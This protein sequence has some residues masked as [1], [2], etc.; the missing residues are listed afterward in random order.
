VGEAA[1][2][3]QAWVAQLRC[4]RCTGR[5][6]DVPP[7]CTACGFA[8]PSYGGIPVVM[9]RPHD[10]VDQ[11]RFRLAEFETINESL[12]TRVIADAA[13]PALHPSTRARLERLAV[14]LATHRA[15]L[16]GLLADAGVT[17][18]KRAA[19]EPEGVPGEGS[20]TSYIHQIHR[21]WGWDA[22]GSTENHD[23]FAAVAAVL[24]PEPKLG[25]MLVLGA[26]AC[27]LA[28]DLH[29][30]GSAA[31][32]VAVDINPLPM[33]VSRRVL[34]GEQVRLLELPVAPP[35][36][37]HVAVDRRLGSADGP[38]TG[39]VHLFADA[40]ALPFADASFD[41][42]LTPWFI[43]Q[44]PRDIATLL[45]M[46][47]R[48]LRD[49]GRWINHGPLIY[50]PAHTPVA[51]R[52]AADELFAI[53]PTAGLHVEQQRVDRLTYLQSPACTRG[54]RESVISFVARAGELELCAA[55]EDPAWL[56]QVGLAVPRFAG[57][58]DYEAPHALFATV[59]RLLDG[60]RS[61]EEIAAI[62]V[63]DYSLPPTAAT[64]GV[65]ACLREIWRATRR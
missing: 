39:F 58:D 55:V 4:P 13:T 29:R 38:A 49:G 5:C 28:A 43:D 51:A 3:E 35:D 11:W 62:L 33:I 26:G 40:L 53:A 37:D 23:A 6:V 15:V 7:S 36:L 48:V 57:L 42:V 12:R 21:D 34:A 9:E 64:A 56:G 54:R 47:R 2:E 30:Y 65:T 8:F 41:T 10:L 31:F 22:D 27:R 61:T 32:T 18:A 14:A 19:P 44:V 52:Y 16:V 1:G 63:R 59:A 46:I 17:P 45:P 60:A 50:N 24:G 20:T 25:A